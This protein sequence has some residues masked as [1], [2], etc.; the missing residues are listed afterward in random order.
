MSIAQIPASPEG[1]KTVAETGISSQTTTAYVIAT[2]MTLRHFNSAQ[3]EGLL[4]G[5]LESLGGSF[6]IV[7]WRN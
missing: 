3:K 4:F 1:G 6:A 5:C 7:A 2:R